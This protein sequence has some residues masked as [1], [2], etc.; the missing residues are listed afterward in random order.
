MLINIILY[1]FKK[2]AHYSSQKSILLI[3]IK[4][5]KEGIKNIWEYFFKR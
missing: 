1:T 3:F 4:S 5:K 2:V